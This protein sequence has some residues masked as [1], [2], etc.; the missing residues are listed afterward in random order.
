MQK[1]PKY[2]LN[3]I[4]IYLNLD[5]LKSLLFIRLKDKNLVLFRIMEIKN[6]LKIY[7]KIWDYYNRCYSYFKNTFWPMKLIYSLPIIDYKYRHTGGT[8]YIDGVRKSDMDSPIMVGVDRYK[9]PFIS[10]KY[11][12]R[13]GGELISNSKDRRAIAKVLT[14]FQRYTDSNRIWCK[15]QNMYGT[16]LQNTSTALN[17][18]DK[19]LLINN[20]L[21]HKSY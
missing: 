6:Q 9:R 17:E 11:K 18:E 7:F 5:D 1:L 4:Y 15:A 12:E 21:N 3:N 10:I 20:I 16:I 2:L 8:D 14:I 19:L 13:L